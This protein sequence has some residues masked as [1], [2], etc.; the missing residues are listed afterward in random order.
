MREISEL[1]K[2]RPV[3]PLE[4][5]VWW[6]E[7]VLRHEDTSMMR[8][9]GATQAWYQRRLLDV[10]ALILC[11]STVA[12][13]LILMLMATTVKGIKRISKFYRVSKIGKCDE[14]TN[15]NTKKIK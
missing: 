7:Y 2:D 8:L 13:I 11:I 1:F 4:S 12:V 14:N 10:W 6:T 9:H 3:Q 15:T 5:A